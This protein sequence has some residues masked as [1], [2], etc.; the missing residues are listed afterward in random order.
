MRGALWGGT[1]RERIL[2]LREGGTVG[3]EG[4]LGERG[5]CRGGHCR[6]GGT[7]GVGHWR[8]EGHCRE[9]HCRAL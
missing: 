1:R 2:P 7:V 3:G 9:E 8:G 4:T 6:G 5:Y